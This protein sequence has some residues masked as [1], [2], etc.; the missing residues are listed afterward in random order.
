MTAVGK[1]TDGGAV[2][3]GFVSA[4]VWLLLYF[5][6][7]CSFKNFAWNF[8]F[9]NR[10]FLV[11]LCSFP[12]YFFIEIEG[13]LKREREGQIKVRQCWPGA[14]YTPALCFCFHAL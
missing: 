13:L 6:S 14:I 9:I 11:A 7:F 2:E 5:V 10:S 12:P 8:F 3:L 4:L 1:S